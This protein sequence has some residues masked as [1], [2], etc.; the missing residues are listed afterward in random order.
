M[1]TVIVPIHTR[2][3]NSNRYLALDNHNIA[4]CGAPVMFLFTIS[5]NTGNLAWCRLRLL[6]TA[7][8]VDEEG[9]CGFEL[10]SC[11]RVARTRLSQPRRE[12]SLAFGLTGCEHSLAPR[13]R[14]Q[15]M[16]RRPILIFREDDHK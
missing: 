16:R 6:S 2:R 15:V 7:A 5:V 4:T 9:Q 13:W 11:A 1:A 12:R 10:Y 3:S 8:P 14:A